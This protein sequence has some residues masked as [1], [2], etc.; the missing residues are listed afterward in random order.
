MADAAAREARWRRT[1]ITAWALIG[2][3]ILVA[4]A[5]FA[6]IN[7]APA[8]VPFG[9][10][11]VIVYLFR[12]PVRRLEKRGVPRGW[13][14]GICYV[15]AI[16]A[17]VIAGVFIFP[18]LADQV[19]Q[20]IDAF[21]HYY[22]S[23]FAL[24][25][26]VQGQFKT[27]SLPGWVDSALVSIR[28]SVAK[29]VMQ[30]SSSLAKQ[31]FSVG[32]GA[33]SFLLSGFLALVVAF[34][35]LKDIDAI[36]REV[37]LLAGPRGREEASVVFAKVSGVLSGYLRGQLIVSTATA[38]MVATVFSI[39]GV[40]YALVL[41]LLAGVLNVIPWFGPM[42]AEIVSAIV[43]VF[44]SPWLALVAVLVILG[45]QQVT[46]MF[47]TPRVMSEQVDLHPLL[48]I[49]SLLAGNA[50]AGFVGMILAIPVA[51]IGKGL[52][53]YYFEKWTDSKLSTEQGAL[54]R[55]KKPDSGEDDDASVAT[56]EHDSEE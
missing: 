15:V 9:L 42:I 14:I 48:V 27:I 19:R 51:A 13:G 50:L 49:F 36:K 7:V 52:F 8:L 32:G 28:D 1:A 23:A 2:I 44:V 34:W 37:M 43:A 3:L 24:W 20:F 35:V 17:L 30:W 31:I 11:L 6:L 40:P 18:P 47:I 21:P 53:V 26:Q 41:G 22:D 29:Q 25:Q 46:D 10:A 38:V 56:V 55:E 45:A 12:T 54:F 39:L 33:L 16:G 5:F 4:A